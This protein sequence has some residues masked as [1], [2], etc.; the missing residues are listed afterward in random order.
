MLPVYTGPGYEYYRVGR[1][2]VSTDET[3]WMAGREGDWALVMYQKNGGGF[4]S[5]YVDASK[6]MYRLGGRSLNL[7]SRKATMVRDCT[8]TDDPKNISSSIC[9]L[10]A[11]ESVTFLADYTDHH[12]WAYIEAWAEMPIRGFVL[13]SDI[14][15][16]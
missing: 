15:I 4:R 9:M 13:M 7:V 2:S 14:R 10:S 16:Q 5:G 12:E 8:M 1:A 11:G 3:I 6:L